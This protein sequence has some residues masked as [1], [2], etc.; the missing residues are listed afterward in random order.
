[1]ND[2]AKVA[3]MGVKVPDGFYENIELH[4]REV[5]Y[6]VYKFPKWKVDKDYW[7]SNVF[8][9]DINN[10]A[11]KELILSLNQGHG[12]GVSENLVH[13]FH[14][15]GEKFVEM[16]VEDPVKIAIKNIQTKI[17]NNE[18]SFKVGKVTTFIDLSSWDKES[19]KHLFKDKATFGSVIHW[20]TIQGALKAKVAAWVTIAGSVGNAE[21][22]YKY[23]DGTYVADKVEFVPG[24]DSQSYSYNENKIF[25]KFVKRRNLHLFISK[26]NNTFEVLPCT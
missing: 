2:E 3:V 14:K 24:L 20:E 21:I 17:A 18:A 19:Q 9:E 6:Q 25:Y 7:F 22:T 12:S 10:D 13:V 8:Y 15:T 1:M 11:K 5:P 23:I 16:P 4:H 26:T